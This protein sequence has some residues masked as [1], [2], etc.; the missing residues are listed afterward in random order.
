MQAWAARIDSQGLGHRR[1][2]LGVCVSMLGTAVMN[3][4]A[5]CFLRWGFGMLIRLALMTDCAT[6]RRSKLAMLIGW[7]VLTASVSYGTPIWGFAADSFAFPP[8]FDHSGSGGVVLTWDR[9]KRTLHKGERPQRVLIV[10]GCG[11]CSAGPPV[12][13]FTTL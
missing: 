7:L 13:C 5:C 11:L 3:S 10:Q 8:P 9:I 2:R 6:V 4:L 1:Q 12:C